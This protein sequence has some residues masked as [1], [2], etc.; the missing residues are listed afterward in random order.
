[1]MMM[2]MLLLSLKVFIQQLFR[3]VKKMNDQV[4]E[5]IEKEIQL[6]GADSSRITMDMVNS[7]ILN[8][9]YYVFPNSN[10]T[11]VCITLLNGFTVTGE[12]ACVSRDNFDEEVGRSL[13]K[14]NART[15]IWAFEAYLLKQ[16]LFELK[17]T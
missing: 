9:D 14:N 11:V 7:A 5:I 8:E 13:A 3:K 12:A 17:E 15:K 6:R 10:C 16:R 2:I 1:M 4:K